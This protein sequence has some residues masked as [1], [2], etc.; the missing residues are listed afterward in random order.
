MKLCEN[1]GAGSSVVDLDRNDTPE[2]VVSEAVLPGEQDGVRIV[3]DGNVVWQS[4]DVVGGILA[5][6]GGEIDETGKVQA[7]LIAVEKDGTGSRVYLL[8]K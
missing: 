8:G 1:A 7:L 2:L 3:A 5:V 6:A 4:R